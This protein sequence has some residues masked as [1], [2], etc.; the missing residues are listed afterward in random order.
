MFDINRLYWFV[1]GA[2]YQHLKEGGQDMAQLEPYAQD[3][4]NKVV[5]YLR[6]IGRLDASCSDFQCSMGH[7]A[8]KLFVKG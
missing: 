7:E 4:L 3:T 6:G 8:K 5:C 2:T 1:L